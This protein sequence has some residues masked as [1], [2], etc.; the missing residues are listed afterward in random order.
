MNRK[1]LVAFVAG[2]A[3]TG[4]FSFKMMYE[5]K[6]NTAE[7]DQVQGIYVFTDSK[8]ISEYDYIGS[9]KSGMSFSG[10]QYSDIRDKLIKKMK[11]D[12]PD[13]NGLILSLQ[14]GGTDRAD[15]IKFK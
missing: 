11:K 4:L 1:S 3:I 5:P 8:P 15:A 6:K 9:V 12:F 2:I 7:V 13:A 10:S 14:A